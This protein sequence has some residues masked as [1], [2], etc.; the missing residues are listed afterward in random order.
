MTLFE[1]TGTIG[2][3][4]GLLGG[5]VFALFAGWGVFGILAA[6]VGGILG[7]WIVGVGAGHL[8]FYWI[9]SKDD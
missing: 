1:L 4:A 7:G 5:L 2:A 6:I 9:E 3:F 8:L